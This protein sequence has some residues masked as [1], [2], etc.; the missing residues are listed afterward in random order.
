[1]S[2]D[3]AQLLKTMLDTSKTA[4]LEEGVGIANEFSQELVDQITTAAQ[5]IN[6]AVQGAMEM[7]PSRTPEA[8]AIEIQA[9]LESIIGSLATSL[10]IAEI[11]ARRAVNRVLDAISGMISGAIGAVVPGL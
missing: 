8:A 11:K 1:M 2:F 3:Y 5:A 6:V 4:L 9:A 7:P 10:S